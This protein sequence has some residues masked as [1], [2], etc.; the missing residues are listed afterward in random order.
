MGGVVLRLCNSSLDCKRYSWWGNAS[1]L[2]AHRAS[3]AQSWVISK[4]CGGI[5]GCGAG[6]WKEVPTLT[7]ELMGTEMPKETIPH[8]R[9]ALCGQ[10]RNPCSIS[11]LTVLDTSSVQ[12]C[13][14][15][16]LYFQVIEFIAPDEWLGTHGGH[17]NAFLHL[18]ESTSWEPVCHGA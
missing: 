13:Y 1:Q 15:M 10:W 9:I 16:P 5:W 6:E 4:H 14:L 7:K 3:S 12:Q 18:P 8:Y 17:V 2:E 11:Y